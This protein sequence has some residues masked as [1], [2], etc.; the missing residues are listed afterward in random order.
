MFSFGPVVL[1]TL[2]PETISHEKLGTPVTVISNSRDASASKKLTKP[3]VGTKDAFASKKGTNMTSVRFPTYQSLTAKHVI[4]T[5]LCTGSIQKLIL[6]FLWNHNFCIMLCMLKSIQNSYLTNT[7]LC[8]QW[9]EFVTSTTGSRM[10]RF[11]KGE[12]AQ[13]QRQEWHWSDSQ[14]IID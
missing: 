12:K 4:T 10:R 1:L 5:V 8:Y 9:K 6:T 13:S 7:F 3:L 14:H 11:N 2:C